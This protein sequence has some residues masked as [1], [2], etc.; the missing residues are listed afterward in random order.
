MRGRLSPLSDSLR[1]LVTR[2]GNCGAYY[3]ASKEG[4]K[5]RWKKE[6]RLYNVQHFPPPIGKHMQMAT[7]VIWPLS[8]AGTR[9]TLTRRSSES[10]SF[11]RTPW[12]L[13]FYLYV[14]L[15]IHYCVRAYTFR[16]KGDNF[17]ALRRTH[18]SKIYRR[19]DRCL[20]TSLDKNASRT[21]FKYSREEREGGRKGC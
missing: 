21:F 18:F 5:E 8:P 3:P 17:K 15:L 13:L 4:R 19:R 2:L 9:A 14:H 1:N 11:R 6:G 7:L 12:G 16:F 10:T 20:K